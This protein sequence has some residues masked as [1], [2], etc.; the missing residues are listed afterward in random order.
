MMIAIA[1]GMSA[2]PPTPYMIL[3]VISQ[4]LLGDR[5]HMHLQSI[6]DHL[7]MS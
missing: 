3:P 1:P 4:T 5:A 2:A 6:V 7:W